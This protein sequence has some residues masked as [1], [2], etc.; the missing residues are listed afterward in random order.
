MTEKENEESAK[1]FAFRVKVGDYEVEIKGE[2]QEV[3]DTVKDL[4]S[5][6]ADVQKAFEPVKPKTTATLTIKKEPAREEMPSQKFPK[7]PKTQNC[8]QSI[9]KL[10]ESDWGKWRPRTVDELREALKA[11][12]MEFSGRVFSGVMLGLVRGGKVK[13]W[14]TDAGTVY[15]LAEEESLK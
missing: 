6:M 8:A 13:R 11:N 7:V 15:I 4:Q 9:L 3:L 5:V 1:P 2:R 14:K 10:L 12:G